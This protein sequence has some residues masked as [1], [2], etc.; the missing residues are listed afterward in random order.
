VTI[1]GILP[2]FAEDTG[3]WPDVQGRIEEA[4]LDLLQEETGSPALEKVA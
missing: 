4:V 3:A 2:E 1:G